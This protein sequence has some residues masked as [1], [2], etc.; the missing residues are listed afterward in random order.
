M[1]QGQGI[2]EGYLLLFV[3]EN[4]IV[5]EANVWNT[6]RE[7]D[8]LEHVLEAVLEAYLERCSGRMHDSKGARLL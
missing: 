2:P 5:L 7:S 1:T 8:V 6:V 3:H 4:S